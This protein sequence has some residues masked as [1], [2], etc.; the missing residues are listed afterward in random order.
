MSLLDTQIV[1][2]DA[3]ATLPT[4]ALDAVECWP[5]YKWPA[6]PIRA[7]ILPRRELV[8]L[9]VLIVLAAGSLVSL[10]AWL[11][12]PGRIGDPIVYLGLTLALGA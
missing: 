5:P 3:P 11:L 1:D 6:Q 4:S 9:R 10:M 7:A 8:K 2:T 12:S